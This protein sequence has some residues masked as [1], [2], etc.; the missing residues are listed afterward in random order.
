MEKRGEQ[1]I[2]SG[3]SIS[4]ANST[5]MMSEEMPSSSNSLALS[6]TVIPITSSTTTS[7][8]FDI[9][10][11]D[12]GDKESL[13]FMDLLD[14]NQD[15]GPSLFD[16]F[17]A[18]IVPS[19]PLPSPASTVPESSE[20]LN[21][22]ATPNSS[23]ISSSSN[24]AVNND[25]PANKKPG[26]EEDQDQDQ[27]KNKKQLKPKKKNQKRQR[28][29]RFAFMTKSEVDHLDDGYR[30]RKYGQK[31]VKNS[32]YPRSYY[33]CTSAGCGVKK[34]VERSSE[35]P[36]IVVTT[37]EGQHTHPSPITPRGSI[38]IL[39][40]SAAFATNS[41]FI[42]PQPHQYQQHQHAYM[43]TSTPS[44]NISTTSPAFHSPSFSPSFHQE[45]RFC[46]STASLFRD[47]GLLQDIVPS[48]MRK[49]ATE[50]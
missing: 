15:F 50:E 9:M 43:Y 25:A 30:W 29:P 6:S 46:P 24:E 21:A 40:D 37:Y 39:Q 11:C 12:I 10:P 41:T 17:P 27:D 28:E 7:S 49:E 42:V 48:Q 34:R 36:T 1:M 32:P 2:K 3:N 35:D 33:R 38:A 13:S 5:L 23:S 18:P 14:R 16:W 4:M 8:I 31:A 22:P 44:L 45:R 20:V 26:E 19:Q 47:H